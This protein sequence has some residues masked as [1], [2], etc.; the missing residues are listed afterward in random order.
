[1][2]L[3]V[4]LPE[5]S[6]PKDRNVILVYWGIR[7]E[8]D[9]LRPVLSEFEKENPNI[10]VNYVKQ[11]A[12]DYKDKLITRINN[13]NGPDV[14][15][16]HN[17]WYETLQDALLP[18]PKETIEKKEF[19]D[20]YY[21]VA[22]KDLIRNG[23]IYGIPIEMDTLTLFV[24]T[25]LFEEAAVS[26]PTTWQEFIET[27]TKLTK[28]DD[29]GRITIAGAGIGT[30]DNVN[31]APDIISLLFAQNGVNFDDF[32][33]S[34][35]QVTD[36]L[37]F[38]TNF[39]LVENNV[40]DQTL[41]PSIN[42]FSEGKLAMYFGYSSDYFVI[43]AANPNLSFRLASSPQLLSDNRVNIAS[44]FADGLSSKSENQK[45]ALL[46]LKFLA[47]SETQK[48]LYEAASKTRAFGQPYGNK[49]LAEELK[50]T[51]GFIFAD[52]ARSSIS[53]PFT[54]G[55]GDDGLDNKLNAS[56][57]DAVLEILEGGSVEEATNSLIEKYTQITEFLSPQPT[58]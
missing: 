20:N 28:R 13:G 58:K 48:K 1:M 57:K 7:E 26:V 34:K 47:R 54:D 39:S 35:K 55:A 12:K 42:A 5:L 45:E 51:D 19:V 38:Y 37:R 56:L 31:H 30:F 9:T 2:I 8:P 53:T 15:K 21:T 29:N 17:S 46:L 25:K 43:K 40:W 24:N 10:K 36:A 41:D 22:Q 44:Y 3:G 18:L 6:K 32:Q 11:D 14:F 16:F 23:A 33:N 4:L 52:Q 27:S 50:G 49:N